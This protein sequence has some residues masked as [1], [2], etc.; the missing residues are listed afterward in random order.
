[1]SDDDDD[2]FFDDLTPAEI[3]LIVHRL[4]G[5]KDLARYWSSPVFVARMQKFI[6]DAPELLARAAEYVRTLP[7]AEHLQ[8]A[9]LAGHGWYPTERIMPMGIRRNAIAKLAQDE[10][11]SEAHGLLTQ[12]YASN[13][14]GY[15]AYFVAAY[16]ERTSILEEAVAAVRDEQY[17]VAI[18][19]LLAQVDGVTKINLNVDFYARVRG[20]KAT[21][22]RR[23]LLK[24]TRGSHPE[25]L[26]ELL[27]LSNPMLK[28][29]LTAPKEERTDPAQ[30]YRHAVMHG[31]CTNYATRINACRSISLL[32]Y[33][34]GL[35]RKLGHVDEWDMPPEYNPLR[36]T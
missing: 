26:E 20:K 30:L 28:L 3:A 11:R 13:L 10:T 23:R 4:S 15:Q 1:M 19:T 7:P 29:P 27:L 25:S 6:A 17:A 5:F 8:L 2:D 16:P 9:V 35:L 14:P 34:T 32:A 36:S 18:P 12:H 22:R 21:D 24:A 33:V 31:R